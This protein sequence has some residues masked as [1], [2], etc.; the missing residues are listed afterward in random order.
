MAACLVASAPARALSDAP[1]PDATPAA[2]EVAGSAAADLMKKCRS[3]MKSWSSAMGREVDEQARLK[4]TKSPTWGTIIR[5]PLRPSETSSL[6]AATTAV[7]WGSSAL[8]WSANLVPAAP[9]LEDVNMPAPAFSPEGEAPATDKAFAETCRLKTRQ[10]LDF[11][12]A[13]PLREAYTLSQQ[14]GP[15]LRTDF[16]LHR[17]FESIAPTKVSR[18][19][20]WQHDGK[21]YFEALVGQHLEP[22]P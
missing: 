1:S 19:A 12:K 22:L 14:W 16:E 20:C 4:V 6:K 13:V 8:K 21:W 18:S 2:D 15:V 7:C 10:A 3:E 11:I 5:W 9:A 17:T